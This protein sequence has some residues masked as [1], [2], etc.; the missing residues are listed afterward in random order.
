MVLVATPLVVTVVVALV[1][2]TGIVN[3]GAMIANELLLERLTV[4]PPSASPTRYTVPVDDIGP[5][6]LV[7]LTL[8]L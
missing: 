8:K 2:P 7:G 6:T 1:A 4:L 5:T 3:V